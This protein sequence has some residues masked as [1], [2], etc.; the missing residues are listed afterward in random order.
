MTRQTS[1]EAHNKIKEDGMLSKKR[2]ETYSALFEYGPATAAELSKK[3][4]AKSIVMGNI[5][6]RLFELKKLGVVYE[7]TER[8]CNV[9]GFNVIE[10]DV[11][12][13]LPLTLKTE[14][15]EKCFFCGGTGLMLSTYTHKKTKKK[16][17][18]MDGQLSLLDGG[19]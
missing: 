18:V 16:T 5:R 3:V 9:T 11:T 17:E 4:S 6:S 10:W 7:V 2:L 19:V 15:K 1:I 13:K 12:D 8:K 14:K